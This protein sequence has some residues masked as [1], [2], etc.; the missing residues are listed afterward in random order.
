MDGAN[1]KSFTPISLTSF[2]LKTMKKVI[3]NY[4]SMLIC[5]TERMTA[6]I[7]FE[8]KNRNSE[9]HGYNGYR[10]LTEP[11]FP[12]IAVKRKPFTK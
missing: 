8:L 10:E 11:Y 2:V 3:D 5:S 6:T 12:S 4:I 9:I 1:P 7:F